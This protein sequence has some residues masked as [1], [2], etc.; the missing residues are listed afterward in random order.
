MG[1][2]HKAH[3]EEVV[4]QHLV[5]GVGGAKLGHN[6]QHRVRLLAGRIDLLQL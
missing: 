1:H 3:L 5:R 6:T 2:G 4:Q